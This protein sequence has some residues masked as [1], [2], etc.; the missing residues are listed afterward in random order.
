[1]EID[2][3]NHLG[4]DFKHSTITKDKV[5]GYQPNILNWRTQRGFEIGTDHTPIVFTI[6]TNPIKIRTK[7]KDNYN[8]VDW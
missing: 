4:P 5:M 1:M 8:L 2:G 7:A 6:S 3:L